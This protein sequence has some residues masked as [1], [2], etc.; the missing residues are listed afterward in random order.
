MV[1]LVELRL[2]FIIHFDCDRH[3]SSLKSPGPDGNRFGAANEARSIHPVF[4]GTVN[5]NFPVCTS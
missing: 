1:E 4:A 2:E 5:L 3:S